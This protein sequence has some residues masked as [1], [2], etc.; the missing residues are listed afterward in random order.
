VRAP[1]EK[2]SDDSKASFYVV[3]ESV[4]NDFPNYYLQIML[5]YFNA[6]EKRVHFQTDNSE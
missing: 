2:K 5:G 1:S 3:L 4:F 6:K